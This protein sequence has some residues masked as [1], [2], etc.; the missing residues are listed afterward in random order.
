MKP[1]FP[2]GE[3][4][5][6]LAKW[7][8]LLLLVGIFVL[9]LFAVFSSG[10]LGINNAEDAKKAALDAISPVIVMKGSTQYEKLY[11][12]APTPEPLPA[13][14][15]TRSIPIPIPV[16]TAA[17][18]EVNAYLPGA[19]WEKQ[20]FRSLTSVNPN[21]L[22]NSSQRKPMDFGVV[23]YDHKWVNSYSWWSDA[24]GQYYKQQPTPGNK[25]L[26][27]WVHEELFGDPSTH[28]PLIPGFNVR[29][30]NVQY[31]LY[32]Y[33]ND[34]DYNPV[35]TILE[36]DTKADYYSTSRTSAFGFTRTYMGE[37]TKFG[38]WS[39][40]QKYDLYIGKGNAWDGYIIFQVPASAND[41]DTILVGNFGSYG[42]AYWKFDIY[43]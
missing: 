40:E 9:L 26:F 12:S 22:F 41:S 7:G 27:V 4:S 30:F 1:L 25:Y 28:I 37:S 35:N 21:G 5:D 29:T 17:V 24:N 15:P 16:K 19:R 32:Q 33:F 39:A 43:V 34:T 8:P 14:T 31:K 38:G 3:Y 2:R 20:W 36:F 10:C 18:K 13:I 42:Q 23:V 6:T 11:P